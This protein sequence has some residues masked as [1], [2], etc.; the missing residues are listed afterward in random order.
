MLLSLITKKDLDKIVSDAKR[1]MASMSFPLQVS[2]LD[3]ESRD[4][5]TVAILESVLMHLNSREL[6]IGS[7]S[8]EYTDPCSAHDPE[9]PLEEEEKK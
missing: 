3:V 2:K 1:N 8:V 6:L 7:V 9:T 4:F 5:A